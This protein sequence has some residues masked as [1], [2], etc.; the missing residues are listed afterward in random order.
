MPDAHSPSKA[1]P[2]LIRFVRELW[3]VSLNLYRH[4][5]K[6]HTKIWKKCHAQPF[7]HSTIF[8]VFGFRNR[9]NEDNKKGSAK[10]SSIVYPHIHT[11]HDIECVAAAPLHLRTS[12]PPPPPPLLPQKSSSQWNNTNTAPSGNC[13]WF[14]AL[15]C[16]FP[17]DSMVSDLFIF[18]ILLAL[19]P[20]FPAHCLLLIRFCRAEFVCF[21]CTR[22]KNHFNYS[23]VNV[24]VRTSVL[25][26]G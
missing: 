16:L 22:T 4:I 17:N 10:E 11:Q 1:T 18:F 9:K 24:A 20:R 2:T 3:T 8:A 25:K 15:C 6:I 21:R 26:A 7:S 5:Q 19:L 14:F 13:Y 23:N 12:A